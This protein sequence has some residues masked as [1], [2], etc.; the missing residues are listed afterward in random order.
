MDIKDRFAAAGIVIGAIMLALAWQASY[1]GPLKDRI[2]ERRAAQSATTPLPENIEVLRDLPYGKDLAQRFDVYLPKNIEPGA[3]VIFMA[4]GGGW[5][6][7]DKGMS[8]VVNNKVAR[9]I[10]RGFIFVSANYRMLPG[11]DP[12]VQAEDLQLAFR[13]AQEKASSWGGD[14]NKFILMGHSAG[15]HLAALIAVSPE[16]RINPPLATIS[17]DSGA[18]N[19]VET[20]QGKHFRLHDDAFGKDPAFW[21]KTSP[22]HAMKQAT[23]PFLIVCSA[24]RNDDSC[25]EGQ[26]FA[27]KAI[28]LGGRAEV[29]REDLTHGEIN[30]K[31]G[32][33]NAYTQR[34]EAFLSSLDPEVKRRLRQ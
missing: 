23:Q 32:Q 21:E 1:A 18:L 34:V 6:R 15:A 20:M 24:Q 5:R 26:Q 28:S 19:V 22:Y 7:G 25:G 31:L 8:N 12:Y 13:T 3:P 29:L 16:I 14:R 33:E 10:P 17:L 11:A 9:W 30:A 2:A 27:D 4:H